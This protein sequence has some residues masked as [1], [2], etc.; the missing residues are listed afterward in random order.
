MRLTGVHH[1][2]LSVSDL[3]RTATWYR[4]VLGFEDMLRYR[5]DTIGGTCHILTHPDIDG[6]ILSFMQWDAPNGTPFDE[7]TLGLDHLSFGVAD[8]AALEDRRHRLDDRTSSIRLPN[9][10]SSQCSCFVTPTASSLNSAPPSSSTMITT[11]S[12]KPVGSGY[13]GPSPETRTKVGR[14]VM[15]PA[16]CPRSSSSSSTATGSLL[17]A[18]DSP[19][20]RRHRSLP[21]SD[22]LSARERSSSGSSAGQ[23]STCM[24]RSRSR[25]AV[26]S[27]GSRSS[28][29]GNPVV[30]SRVLCELLKDDAN[31]GMCMWASPR[32]G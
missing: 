31:S 6:F 18:S 4:D 17:T 30:L 24:H 13:Q 5:N 26:P 20:G 32:I 29:R 10:Q 8:R 23:L 22:G 21:H 14:L 9:C 19:C 7:H 11:P 2:T 28:S 25:W 15:V 1:A 16:V 27:I 3:D 12:M